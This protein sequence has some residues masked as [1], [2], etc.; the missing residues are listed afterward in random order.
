MLQKWELVYF[1]VRG[2]E[3][4]QNVGPRQSMKG[5]ESNVKFHKLH[6]VIFNL[7]GNPVL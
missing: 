2:R 7:V 4:R 5:R 1:R 6:S 3:D